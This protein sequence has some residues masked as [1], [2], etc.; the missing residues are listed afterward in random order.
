MHNKYKLNRHE[1]RKQHT[2]QGKWFVMKMLLEIN[3]NMQMKCDKWACNAITFHFQ[4]PR[5]TITNLR[6]NSQPD[7]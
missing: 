1:G 4:S 2:V 3:E 5:T 7:N 6:Q